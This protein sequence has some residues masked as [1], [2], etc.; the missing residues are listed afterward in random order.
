MLLSRLILTAAFSLAALPA[1]AND[2]PIP[3]R[4][5]PAEVLAAAASARTPLAVQSSPASSPSMWEVCR[6]LS[7]VTDSADSTYQWRMEAFRHLE[8]VAQAVEQALSAAED[9]E[10]GLLTLTR[11]DLE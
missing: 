5:Q 3:A 6:S 10:D 2:S 4:P 1:L 9:S 7:T 8:C 11:E